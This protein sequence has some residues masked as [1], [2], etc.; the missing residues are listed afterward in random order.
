M[1]PVWYVMYMDDENYNG[2]LVPRVA[3]REPFPSIE[4]AYAFASTMPPE[5]EA[6]VVVTCKKPIKRK[7]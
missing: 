2:V 1:S 4:S 7:E 3:R 6:F 5:C